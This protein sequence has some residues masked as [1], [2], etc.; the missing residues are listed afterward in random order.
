ML[1]DGSRAAFIHETTFQLVEIILFGV[2]VVFLFFIA[3]ILI[4]AWEY[5]TAAEPWRKARREYLRREFFETH[6]RNRLAQGRYKEAASSIVMQLDSTGLCYP[7]NLIGIDN[8]SLIHYYLPM[9]VPYLS[10]DILRELGH[11]VKGIESLEQLLGRYPAQVAQLCSKFR[12]GRVRRNLMLWRFLNHTD[13]FCAGVWPED[14]LKKYIDLW[15]EIR[16][17]QKLVLSMLEEKPD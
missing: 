14:L 13:T 11:L 9:V 12:G 15:S 1:F 16:W 7:L 4:F 8:L 10:Y 5:R 17:Y 2:I 6:I 3:L